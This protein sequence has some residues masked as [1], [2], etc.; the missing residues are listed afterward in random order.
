MRPGHRV[1]DLG[2]GWG[3]PTFP[4]AERYGCN[5]TGLSISEKQVAFCNARR[6]QSQA[7]EKVEF[8]CSD[9]ADYV[10]ERLFDRVISIGMLEHVGKY[11]YRVFS[12]KSRI[13]WLKMV[14][15]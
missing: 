8:I 4:L 5:V 13:S 7:P 6:T 3:F 2:S 10:P 1:L 11:Q 12:T 15:P 14:S 9:Y